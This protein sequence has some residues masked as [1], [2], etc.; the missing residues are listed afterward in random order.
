MAAGNFPGLEEFALKG[1]HARDLVVGKGGGV[2]NSAHVFWLG[3]GGEEGRQIVVGGEL[4]HGDVGTLWMAMGGGA[5]FK[6][7]DLP[8]VFGEAFG[9]MHA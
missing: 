2:E 9:E 5:S 8:A 1:A 6:A 4:T 3:F 7:G